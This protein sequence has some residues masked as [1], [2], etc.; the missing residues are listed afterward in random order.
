M[1][2]NPPYLTNQIQPAGYQQIPQID[3]TQLSPYTQA[4]RAA[5]PQQTPPELQHVENVMNKYIQN[6]QYT[7][8]NAGLA[9]ALIGRLNQQNLQ[10][11][12]MDY[13]TA[14]LKTLNSGG[15][16]YTG[17]QAASERA[18][19]ELAPYTSLAELQQKANANK[20]GGATGDLVSAVM[21]DNPGMSFT[22]A[23]YAVQTGWRQ[24]LTRDQQGA[25]VP[26]EGAPSALQTLSNAKQMGSNQ[27]NV[28]TAAEEKRQEKIGA[29][30]ITDIEKKSS[31]QKQV[32]NLLD[33]LRGSYKTLSDLGGSVDVRKDAMDNAS[34]YIGSSGVGQAFGRLSGTQTQSIRNQIK[35]TMPL[36]VNAIRQATAMGAKGMDSEKELAF[37]VDAATNPSLDIQANLA[38]LDR[39]EKAYGLS[40]SGSTPSNSGAFNVEDF[41]RSKGLQ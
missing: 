25:I 13:A 40:A 33:E 14:A 18:I 29:G 36:L 8:G 9:E 19:R 39:L 17:Q 28:A 11:S 15:D 30:E 21:A 20:F 7:A 12:G 34:A 23:L 37:Y 26:M 22:D 38:A 16:P 5:L 3:E 27:A 41:I 10:P 35:Q 32:S 24:N 1:P 4:I 6:R 31:G 2:I